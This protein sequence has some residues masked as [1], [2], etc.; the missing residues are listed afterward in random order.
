[1]S[2]NE[3]VGSLLVACALA[4]L[5][6][7]GSE[8]ADADPSRNDTVVEMQADTAV[9]PPDTST[10]PDPCKPYY[11]LS[12]GHQWTCCLP[13]YEGCWTMGC[14]T[15]ADG[16]S[17]TLQ[18]EGEFESVPLDD[19]GPWKMVDCG[20][21]DQFELISTEDPSDRYVCDRAK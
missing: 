14:D 19:S 5:G 1:M 11:W 2:T 16:A 13:S 20:C 6:A 4:V 12:W 9:S 8:D 10:G 15:R 17:C 3:R 7:C 18:C 21:E